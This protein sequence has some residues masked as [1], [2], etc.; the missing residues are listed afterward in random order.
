MDFSKK[1]DQIISDIFR[2][3]II[4]EIGTGTNLL[5]KEICMRNRSYWMSGSLEDITKK[6]NPYIRRKTS[7]E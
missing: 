3:L 2:F 6:N 1:K 4:S 5:K 7:K